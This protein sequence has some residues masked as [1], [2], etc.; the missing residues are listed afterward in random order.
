MTEIW[1]IFWRGRNSA[2]APREQGL[3]QEDRSPAR[4]LVQHPLPRQTPGRGSSLFFPLGRSW[5]DQMSQQKCVYR[6]AL[7]SRI[8]RLFSFSF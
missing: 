6:N 4:P 7:W 1:A 8:Q 2:E 5:Q 3:S